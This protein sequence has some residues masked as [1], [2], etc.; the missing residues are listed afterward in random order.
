MQKLTQWT[1]LKCNCSL[2][3]ILAELFV[4]GRAEWTAMETWWNLVP[5]S[6]NQVMKILAQ[7]L[8]LGLLE[9]PTWH[10]GITQLKYKWFN[11]QSCKTQLFHRTKRSSRCLMPNRHHA[12]PRQIT[13]LHAQW[14]RQKSFIVVARYRSFPIGVIITHCLDDSLL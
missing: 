6:R 11:S 1:C 5:P 4:C 12:N 7:S 14:W 13:D 2:N 9:W 3:L 8:I 10:V